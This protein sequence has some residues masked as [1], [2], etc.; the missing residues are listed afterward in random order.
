[1]GENSVWSFELANIIMG[2][3][4]EPVILG[5]MA[6]CGAETSMGVPPVVA[7]ALKNSH[8]EAENK[9]NNKARSLYFTPS[10]K[11]AING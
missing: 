4:V 1:M 3:F 7:L 10:P 5:G 6:S 11:W 2:L 9:N 8:S